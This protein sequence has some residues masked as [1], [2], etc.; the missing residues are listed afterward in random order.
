MTTRLILAALLGVTACAPIPAP[1][2]VEE[3]A[4]VYETYDGLPR[5]SDPCDED[6][7]IGGTGCEQDAP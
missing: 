4:I 3:P 6:D 5:V 2:P 1:A 7:G